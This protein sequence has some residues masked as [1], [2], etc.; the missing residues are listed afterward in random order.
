MKTLNR[1][2]YAERVGVSPAAVTKLCK[3]NGALVEA[4]D[5]GGDII[6]DHPASLNYL[7]RKKLTP[8]K[9]AAMG[10][11][12]SQIP[13]VAVTKQRAKPKARKPAATNTK[14]TKVAARSNQTVAGP[15]VEHMIVMPS[16]GDH[17]PNRDMEVNVETYLDLTLREITEQY[18]TDQNFRT[19]L[20]ARL[21]IEDIKTREM[22]NKI[23]SGEYIPRALV[24]KHVFPFIDQSFRRL[25]EDLPGPLGRQIRSKV[26]AEMDDEEIE[27][28]I[29]EQIGKCLRGVK[30]RTTKLIGEQ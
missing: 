16:G 29:R 20:E 10:L 18:G 15:D 14:Q 19:F 4:Q 30:E 9:L 1:K 26:M 5:H 7:A 17:I 3:G 24:A 21:K 8:G 23:T 27:K 2:Q 11:N 13:K 6:V 12:P 22:K 25:V 28:F